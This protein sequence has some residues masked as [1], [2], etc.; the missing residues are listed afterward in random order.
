MRNNKTFQLVLTSLF[1]AII[2]IMAFT[3]L[4]YI[5]LVVIN[6]TII[7]I[8]VI[9]GALF[10]GPKNGAV[11]GF[12]FGITSFIKNTIMPTSL[13]AFV[14]SP[15]L[16]GSM[17]GPSGILKSFF[18]CFVPRILVGV[19]PFF[20]YV[21]VKKAVSSEK[22]VLWSSVLN[23][24]IGLFLFVG[25]YAFMGK[26]FENTGVLQ[27]ILSVLAAAAVAVLLEW[28]TL[29]K[30]GKIMAFSYAGVTGAMVN[31]LLVMGSIYVL[32]KDA[33][34]EAL[35][36]EPAAVLATIGGVISFNGVV[37]A[38]VAAVLVAGIGVVLNRIQPIQT[39]K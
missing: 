33:Y 19:V 11:L 34:A 39:T 30:D 22:K 27:A 6:A 1:S 15:V 28:L 5:P 20:V 25:L 12:I 36:I 26:V 4:G 2:I 18:I 16:A 35:G 3:P 37:E 7:H 9:L 13:S 8:P 24:L 17:L 31:T 21:A 10:C 29:K 14:F 38:I 32:Y 23:G